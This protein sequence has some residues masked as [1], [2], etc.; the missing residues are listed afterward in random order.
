VAFEVDGLNQA[1]TGKQILIPPNSRSLGAM[2]AV[3]VGFVGSDGYLK[4][5]KTPLLFSSRD[6]T[7]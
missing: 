7:R 5:D 2:T 3:I 4:V 6:K 1:L